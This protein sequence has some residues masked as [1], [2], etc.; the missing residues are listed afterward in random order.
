LFFQV[1]GRKYL[2]GVEEEGAN[3]DMRLQMGKEQEAV[4]IC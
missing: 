3:K 4:E 1:K 2:E